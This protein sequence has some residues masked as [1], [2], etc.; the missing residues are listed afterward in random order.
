[1]FWIR[2]IFEQIGIRV[3]GSNFLH[4]ITDP[5]T[6]PDPALFGRGFQDA[7]KNDFF[8]KFK[9]LISYCR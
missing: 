6:A 5:D 2:D 9:L 8:P 7:D 1:M 3:L 4:W